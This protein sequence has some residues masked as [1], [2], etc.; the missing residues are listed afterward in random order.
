MTDRRF[1][2]PTGAGAGVALSVVVPVYGCGGCLRELVARIED[3]VGPVVDN[4]EVVLV[5]D[6]SPDDAW[7]V[8]SELARQDSR[9]RAFRL[10]RNFGQHAAITAGLTQSRGR[11]VAVMDCDLQEPP[12]ELPRLLAKAD[13]GYDVVHAARRGWRHS[14]LRRILSRG[15]RF[16]LL[17]S[18]RRG[19]F[20]TLS[21][22]SRKVVD[23]LLLLGDRHREYLLMLDWLGFSSATV[24]FDHVGRSD[25]KSAYTARRLI[26]VALDGMFFRTTALLRMIVLLG[27]VVALCGA[28]LA[29]YLSI[30]YFTV[31]APTG[32]TSLALLILL[33][34][35]FTIISLGVV[36][37]YVGRVFEQVKQ[38]PLFIVDEQVVREDPP[39]P[40]APPTLP[41][42]GATGGGGPPGRG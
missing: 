42:A 14:R 21:V 17:E 7:D 6:R 11:W 4:Y 10:S 37:I 33:L 5:D 25:G 12:E 1:Q 40:V 34:S 24:E 30:S 36:G 19:E 16:M 18:E 26:R 9:V 15:Y 28:V 22:I 27:F 38:R 8:M 41:A 32:Y 3:S 39:L 29:V 20:S 35:G 13:E 31:G 2:Q 23:A